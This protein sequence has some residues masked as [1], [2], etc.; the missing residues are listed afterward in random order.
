MEEMFTG[1]WDRNRPA[2]GYEAAWENQ[3]ENIDYNVMLYG[4]AENP[5]PSKEDPQYYEYSSIYW[6]KGGSYGAGPALNLNELADRLR[7]IPSGK[8]GSMPPILRDKTDKN[9]KIHNFLDNI[10]LLSAF[11]LRLYCKR[12]DLVI[13]PLMDDPDKPGKQKPDKSQK[14]RREYLGT[15]CW[16]TVRQISPTP[17][18]T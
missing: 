14:L 8:F 3:D 7:G 4:W 13:R 1:R 9:G 5:K 6:E 16:A 12:I 15:K 10:D 2:P 17:P 11:D 18:R